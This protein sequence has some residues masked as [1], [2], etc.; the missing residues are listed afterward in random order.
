VAAQIPAPAPAIMTMDLPTGENDVVVT[1]P[2]SLTVAETN[3]NKC[4]AIV[5][6]WGSLS[7]STNSL[8]PIWEAADL[9]MA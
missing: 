2:G 9:V 8:V 6:V 1:R 3:G 4:L 7:M 5:S